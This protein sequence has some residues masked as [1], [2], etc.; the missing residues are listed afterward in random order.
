MRR[1]VLFAWAVAVW[2]PFVGNAQENAD[3]IVNEIQVENI[4]QFVDPSWNFG[5]WVELYN[6]SSKPYRLRGC[7]VSDDVENLK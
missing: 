7:W 1:N 2:F 6:P 3:L 4:D 5:G